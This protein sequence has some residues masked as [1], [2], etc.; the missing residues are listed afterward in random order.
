MRK[1]CKRKVWSTQIDTIAHAISGA[2][3]TDQKNLN[4]L[5]LGELS[6]LEA[7]RMGAG[8]TTDWL[9][10]N[11]MLNITFTFIRHGIGAEAKADCDQ[12]MNSLKEA[13]QRYERTK[14]MGLDGLGI[15]ALRNVHEWH[16]LQRTN[17]SRSFY[18]QMIEKTRNYIKS[19]G[20][21]VIEI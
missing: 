18:E 12:A 7:M 21:D 6:S 5:R 17:V 8:T 1:R 19:K 4:K 15:E 14:K 13:A 11:D 9:M 16:D 20:K 10:L 3:V 2:A